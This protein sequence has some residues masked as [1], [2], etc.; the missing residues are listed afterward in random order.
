[1]SASEEP[2]HERSAVGP[3]LSREKTLLATIV[4]A[5]LILH[6]LAGSMLIGRPTAPVAQDTASLSSYD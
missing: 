5:F 3:G 1:M 6:V 2:S 4:F